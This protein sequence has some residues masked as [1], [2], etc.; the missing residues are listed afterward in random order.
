MTSTDWK[1]ERLSYLWVETA[2]QII[3]VVVLAP[4]VEGIIA[5]LK[6]I[7]ESRHGPSIFQPYFDLR[8]YL[9]K[10]T[11]LNTDS[12]ALFD[13]A[14]YFVFSTYLVIS[15][16]IPV[17]LPYPVEFSP[18]VDLL[19]G[20]L[21][22]ILAAVIQILAAL[23]ARSSFTALGAGRSVTFSAYAEP[24]LIMVFFAVA[25]ISNSNNPYLTHDLISAS[26]SNYLTLPHILSSVA[27]FM[28]FLFVT[29][30][31]PTESSGMMEFGMIDEARLYEYSGRHMF[32]LKYSSHM[33]QYLLGSV[34]INVFIFPWFLQYGLF[35][36]LLDIPIMLGKWIVVA[37]IVVY[38]EETLAKLR[39]FKIQDY[40][41]LSFALAV[42][43]VITYSLGGL[44]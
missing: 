30:R 13:L 26:I 40:L 24:T 28:L 41:T 33:K 23:D 25:L 39:L 34:L 7:V 15:F 32:F 12:T 9:R 44:L 29:G 19:G 11:L 22:F 14:P 8:K 1:G 38:L 42:F 18:I 31:L 4:L 16:V 21:L 37:I 36:S 35:G 17:V 43:S 10:E 27:F 2:I 3:G 5:R 20:G 6:A